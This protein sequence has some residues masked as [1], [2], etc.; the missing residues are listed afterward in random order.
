MK[1]SRQHLNRSVKISGRGFCA[2][3]IVVMGFGFVL[4]AMP[5]AQAQ[6][7]VVLHTFTGKKD[8]GNPLG[9]LVQDPSA[10][11]Y[12]TTYGGGTAG[13]G[14]LFKLDPT[15]KETVLHNFAG[16]TDGAYPW[17]GPYRD[18]AGNLY[19]TDEAGGKFHYGAAY[20]WTA[21]KETV[22]YSFPGT[23]GGGY[24]FDGVV[25]DSAGNIY[26][27]L[28]K[29]GAH[30]YGG[31]FKLTPSG[32][33]SILYNFEGLTD[34]GYPY[35]SLI[36]DS[37]NNLYG[38]TYWGGTSAEAGVVFKLDPTGKETVLY[39]F[40]GGNDGANP[41][42]SLVRDSAGNLYGTTF[43]GGTA[44]YGVV[45][46]LD[47]SGVETVL[48]SFQGGSDGE[49]PVAGLTMDASGNLFGTTYY[50][51][52]SDFG[53]VFEVDSSGTET[54][55]YSFTGGSDGG[56]PWAGVIEDASGNL[57]GTTEDGGSSG[58]GF[59]TVFKLIP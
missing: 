12:G 56:N 11:L 17:S 28:W 8:G 1:Y 40:K 31:V 59:G 16:K 34:G 49:N 44:G 5:S 15:G 54:V 14:T 10:N 39:T 36:L 3:L 4:G 53:T 29:G 9:G 51:G 21:G 27:T 22:L 55:L 57:Y 35:D 43:S 25:R 32:K 47:T 2:A 33:P 20:K 7:L 46:K 19:G 6:T 13:L 48:H 37:A 41:W 26:T 23:K 24:P 50:G 45:F 38:T 58:Y 52:T 30:G 18:A 42:S